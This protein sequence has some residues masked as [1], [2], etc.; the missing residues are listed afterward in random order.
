[1]TKLWKYMLCFHDACMAQSLTV[2]LSVRIS[3]YMHNISTCMPWCYA[4]RFWALRCP[5]IPLLPLSPFACV[6][7]SKGWLSVNPP[8]ARRPRHHAVRRR[9]YRPHNPNRPTIL[10]INHTPNNSNVRNHCVARRMCGK[11]M[12]VRRVLTDNLFSV[13]CCVRCVFALIASLSH[14]LYLPAHFQTHRQARVGV[15]C[16]PWPVPLVRLR[17]FK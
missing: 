16:D 15:R 17:W 3:V 12:H 13:V 1:M 14:T 5:V 2:C 10:S 7:V 6:V 8:G 11:R 9:S 4:P